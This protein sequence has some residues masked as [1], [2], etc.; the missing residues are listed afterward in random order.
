M[1]PISPFFERLGTALSI[2]PCVNKETTSE[3]TNPK[4][5]EPNNSK[6]RV[7]AAAATSC[8]PDNLRDLVAVPRPQH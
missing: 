4:K 1:A 3:T 6:G 8:G 7:R 2:W 5:T